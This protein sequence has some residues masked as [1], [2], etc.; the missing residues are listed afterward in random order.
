MYPFSFF[1]RLDHLDQQL[2][3]HP[4]ATGDFVDIV[5]GERD[6]PRYLLIASSGPRVLFEFEDTVEAAEAKFAS[7]LLDADVAWR[8]ERMIDLEHGTNYAAL[9]V[10]SVAVAEAF[11]PAA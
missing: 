4:H 1:F 9:A 2:K 6:C 7:L 3:A 5:S 10:A 8:P 11:P